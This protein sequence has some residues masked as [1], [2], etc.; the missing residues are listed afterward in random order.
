MG[1][2]VRPIAPEQLRPWMEAVETAF[3]EDVT[4]EGFERFRAILEPERVLAAFDGQVIVGGGA[5]F[6]FQLTVPGGRL[7]AGGVTAVGMLPTHRRR[8]LLRQMMVRQLADIRVAGE[9][10]AV[11]WAS[12]GNIYQRFGYGLASLNGSIE[13]AR[14]RAVF[15]RPADWS[16]DVRLVDADT[17]AG[18]F[19]PIYAQVAARTPGFYGRDDNWWR[20]RTL[21]D[22][23]SWRRGMSRKF[24]CLLERAGTPAAYAMYRIKDEW[25]DIGSKSA[26]HVVEWMAVDPAATQD[27]WRYLFSVDLMARTTSRLGPIDHPLLLMLDE[28]R[29]LQMRVG[30]G[31]WLRIVDVEAALAGR[32][33]A[34]DGE[35][36]I[37]LADD[38]MP[39]CAGRWRIV[40]SGG[41]A[42]VARTDRPA[43]LRLDTTDLAAIYL[44]GFTVGQL[45]RAGRGEE[46]AAGAHER[47][48]RLFATPTRPWCPEIF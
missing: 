15:R 35:L 18:G 19:P 36:V 48:D 13:I 38:L 25:D 4:D 26:L 33:Y 1:L 3:G 28:P 20:K 39:D 5:A 40:A 17:A 44:G 45:S 9:P 8:G 32:E 24:F 30:D 22:P 43:D 27:I 11:L 6:S 23:E 34:A 47:A 14:E 21:A 41:R 31:L 42:E 46:L 29:R 2:E 7:G 12:E 16:G 37:D 10:L